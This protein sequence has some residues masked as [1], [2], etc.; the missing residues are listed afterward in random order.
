MR[1]DGEILAGSV[2]LHVV[3]LLHK[4]TRT[5]CSLHEQ[6]CF[7][8]Q[9]IHASCPEEV[10]VCAPYAKPHA[11]ICA[12]QDKKQQPITC[13]NLSADVVPFPYLWDC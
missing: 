13:D 11:L 10:L 1:L 6:A 12:H 2:A 9:A 3:A 7:P 8:Y 4:L 5:S